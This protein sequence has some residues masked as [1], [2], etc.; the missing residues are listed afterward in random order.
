MTS[1]DIEAIAR[2]TARERSLIAASRSG[3]RAMDE[4]PDK[5]GAPQAGAARR[6]ATPLTLRSSAVT[7]PTLTKA[8]S[9]ALGKTRRLPLR[10]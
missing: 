2:V 8:G 7:C 1:A 6:C 9:S 3:G 4:S 5:V 10:E